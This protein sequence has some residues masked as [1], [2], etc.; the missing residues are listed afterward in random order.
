[1]RPPVSYRAGLKPVLPAAVF[2]LLLLFAGGSPS[3]AGEIAEREVLP[4]GMI[5]L[6]AEKKAVPII[7][8]V[9]AVKA[10][11]TT[12]SPD[13]A[14]LA[15]LT[16]DLLNEGTLKRSSQEISGAIEFVGGALHTSGGADSATVTLSVLKKDVEL[17]FDLLADVILNPAF[18]Q[19]EVDRRK[20]ILLSSIRQQKEEPGSIASKAFFKA[21]FGAHPYGWPVEGTEES[22]ETI[23][24]EDVAGF[25]R[26]HYLPNNTIMAVVGDISRDELKGLLN[27][28]FRGWQK[29]EVFQ[30]P[31]TAPEPVIGSHVV[32]ISKKTKQAHIMLGHTGFRR[33]NPDYYAVSV[34]NYILGG[35][36]FASRLMDNIRDNRGL[37]YSVHSSFNAMKQAGIFQAGLQTKNESANTAIGE[38]LREMARIQ[39]EPVS[40][41][42]LSDAKA[43]LTGS[44]PLRLDSN[45]KMAN[46]LA[47]VE[48]YDLG[49]D[50][51][52]RYRDLIAKVTT[53]DVLRVA[54]KYLH[55]K[56]YVLVVVGDQ[57]KALLTY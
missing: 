30:N 50:Y 48:M 1:M 16:A 32:K 35:G 8:V 19:E 31:L 22:L 17:G 42:E 29:K 49:L 25:Y 7:K 24:R 14:G 26:T 3:F 45:S 23:T 40:D 9:V 18:K 28:Y 27:K 47:A 4:N 44:F 46:F 51:I 11:S 12:E 52:E 53:E 33:D 57:E 43:Y 38:I 34:M 6:H 39:T 36:G 55:T 20:S 21:V 2:C 13:K 41:R 10:G 56:D 5:L 15:N 37:A 54:R